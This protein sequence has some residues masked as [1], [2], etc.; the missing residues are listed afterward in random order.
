M[1]RASRR[2]HADKKRKQQARQQRRNPGRAAADHY[3]EPPDLTVRAEQRAIDLELESAVHV[4]FASGWTPLDLYEAA[5]RSEPKKVVEYLLAVVARVTERHPAAR[6]H[7]RWRAQLDQLVTARATSL[8]E[9]VGDSREAWT[10]LIGPFRGL[11]WRLRMLP[12]LESVLP[13]PGAQARYDDDVPG[14]DT[15]ILRR[16]R[17]LLAKAESTE[18]E[19]EA[20]ALT[21]KAQALMSRHSIERTLAAVRT[22]ERSQPAVRRIWLENPYVSAKAWL[23]REVARANQC[24]SVTSRDLGLVTVVGFDNDLDVVEILVT[25]LL[26]QAT[27]A[28]QAARPNVQRSWASVTRSFRQSFLIAFA[29]RI[30]ERLRESAQAVQAEA[31]AADGTALLPVLA[32]RAHAVDDVFAATFPYLVTR[33]IRTTNGAGAVAGRVAADLAVLDV[34]RAVDRPRS[35]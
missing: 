6:V 14:V 1:S 9:W 25:S 22:T 34:R 7:P 2:R 35:A 31:S 4:L 26:V 8:A 21:A 19:H 28:M 15:K 33:T 30:G 18:Y 24:R 12:S 23:V 27:R 10:S 3:E 32:D 13:A 16:V 20:A 5:R 11:L 29:G 17:S